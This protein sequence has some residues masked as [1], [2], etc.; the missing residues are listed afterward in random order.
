MEEEISASNIFLA[1][2]INFDNGGDTGPVTADTGG[3]ST[4]NPNAGEGDEDSSSHSF[5][6][7]ST[8]DKA[9]AS[10]LTLIFVFGW[11]GAMGFMLLGG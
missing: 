3:N 7:I 8:G 11:V 4:S 5:A 1:N 2:M 6:P 9:G 10:I